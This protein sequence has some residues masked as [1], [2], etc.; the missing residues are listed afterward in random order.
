MVPNLWRITY[1]A[2]FEDGK[3][4]HMINQAIG[5]MAAIQA[6]ALGGIQVFGPGLSSESISLDGLSQSISTTV[7]AQHAA[8]SPVIAEYKELLYG[9]DDKDTNGI[10]FVLRYYYK[11][12]MMG[13]I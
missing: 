9:K 1:N 4:P 5:L 13:I 11:G 6:M 12:E 3:V 7:N 10:L 8:Y 2:G